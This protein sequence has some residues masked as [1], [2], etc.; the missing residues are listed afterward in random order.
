[1]H[2]DSRPK[3]LPKVLHPEEVSKLLKTFSRWRRYMTSLRD[4]MAVRLMVN[5]GL[6][7][8]EICDLKGDQI[9]LSTRSL[10]V[11]DGKGGKDRQLWL[12]VADRDFL[13]TLTE[14]GPFTE[15]G[16]VFATKEG[17]PILTVHLRLMMSRRAKRAGIRKCSPHM[18]RHTFATEFYRATKDI[19]ALQQ[20][21]VYDSM[22][23]TRI[24]TYTSAEDV[25]EA[26]DGFNI[27]G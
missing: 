27:A 21:L 15:A 22:T 20:I 13:V 16:H 25:R 11:V 4:M 12:S 7:S 3:K 17:N 26:L 14:R 23:T 10:R 9:D 24:Y 18:L 8:Q 6:R 1:M 19:T 2:Y 5:I